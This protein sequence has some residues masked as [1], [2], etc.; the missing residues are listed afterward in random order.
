MKFNF[1]E[2]NALSILLA[3]CVLSL[4]ACGNKQDNNQENGTQSPTP[5]PTTQPKMEDGSGPGNG[6]GAIVRN[7]NVLTLAQAGIEIPITEAQPSENLEEVKVVA[8]L[9]EKLALS[10]GIRGNLLRSLEPNGARKYFKIEAK[11]LNPEK[12]A[13]LLAAYY[14]AIGQ[15]VPPEDKLTLVALT[16]GSETFLLPEFYQL[17]DATARAAIL[18]HEALWV[19]NPKIRLSSVLRA[20][21]AVE[22]LLRSGSISKNIIYDFELFQVLKEALEDK[23]LGMVGAIRKDFEKGSIKIHLPNN[24]GAPIIKTLEKPHFPIRWLLGDIVVEELRT[25]MELN[26]DAFYGYIYYFSKLNPSLL[27]LRELQLLIPDIKINFIS[28][29]LEWEGL[30]NNQWYQPEKIGEEFF[31]LSQSWTMAVRGPN[32]N[33]YCD[34]TGFIARG[35]TLNIKGNVAMNFSVDTTFC[36]YR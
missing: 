17:S 3:I 24:L 31:D 14:S 23:H 21:I 2:R 15:V 1:V 28:Y 22:K 7:G 29:D 16:I 11:D 19:R 12:R 13:K 20:E 33:K 25:S 9:I 10:D 34:I 32:E 36:S 27:F 30:N 18:F 6:G 26:R 4:S 8:A 35:G 5:Q